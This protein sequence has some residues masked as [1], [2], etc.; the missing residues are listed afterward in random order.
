MDSDTLYHTIQDA[1]P[2][3]QEHEYVIHPDYNLISYVGIDG[4]SV[5]DALPNNVEENIVSIVAEGAAAIQL[6][7]GWYGSLEAFYRNKGYWVRNQLEQ[8][9]LYFSWE[10]PDQDVLFTNGSIKR[11]KAIEIPEELSFKQ[12]PKQAFYF[13]EKIKLDNI[14]LSTED[15]IVAYNNN[16]IVGARRWNGKYTDIPAMGYNGTNITSGYCREGDIPTFKIFI[17]QTGE[18]IN[19]D[20]NIIHPWQDLG[21][22]IIPQLSESIPIPEKFNFSYPYPNPFNPST[23]IKFALPNNSNVKIVAYDVMG[24][25]V[26]TILNED[27]NAGYYDINWKPFSLSTGIYFL[28]IQTNQSDLTHKV[29]YIK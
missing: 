12:S 27:L 2:T 26:D 5:A 7:D 10:I 25:H 28:N 4:I 15:W 9:T 20:A 16:I 3:S 21:T 1:I 18:F 19:L 23:V 24:K 29:M 22:N 17:N 11:E 14:S 6:S 8:D 13:I